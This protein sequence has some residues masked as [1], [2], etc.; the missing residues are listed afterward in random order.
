M[1]LPL[2]YLEFFQTVLESSKFPLKVLGPM[3]FTFRILKLVITLN[4]PP[5][6]KRGY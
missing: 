1:F 2:Y 3:S 4:D 5:K 6:Q